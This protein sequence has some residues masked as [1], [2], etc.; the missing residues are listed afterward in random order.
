MRFDVR[1]KT[2]SQHYGFALVRWFHWL[3]LIILT[4]SAGVGATAFLMLTAAIIASR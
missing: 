3:L 2:N 4:I 1:A